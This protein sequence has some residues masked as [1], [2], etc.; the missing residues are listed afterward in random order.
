MSHILVHKNRIH[1]V[2]VKNE[3]VF[4]MVWGADPVDLAS[5]E[6]AEV[7]WLTHSHPRQGIPEDR[8]EQGAEHISTPRGIF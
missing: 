7:A 8:G 2:I 1:T 3:D 4:W 6:S 5:V